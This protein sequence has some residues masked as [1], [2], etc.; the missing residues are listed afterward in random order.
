[1][2]KTIAFAVFFAALINAHFVMAQT[3]S[4]L[5]GQSMNGSTGL[6]SI[7]TG[8]LGWEKGGN[9]GLDLGYRAVI[10]NYDSATHIPAVTMSLFKWVE[11]SSAVDI[12]PD[13]Y[14]NNDLLFGLKVRLPTKK[15]TAIAL[16]GNVQFL[17][18]SNESNNYNAY[19]PYVAITYMGNFFSMSTETTVVF[20][21]TFYSGGPKNNSNIDFGMGFDMAL[22]PNVFKNVL[23]WVIDFANF[24]YSDNSWPNNNEYYHSSSM[25]RGIL[26]TGLR[27]NMSAIPALSR[28]KFLFDVAFNDLFDAGARSITLGAVFGFSP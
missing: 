23:H 1:M 4:S 28:Y 2:K 7:P 21:K 3:D 10:N 9:F 11:I 15:N 25:W 22:F 19:Q 26:N 16:G 13:L 14:R 20:G 5:N 24:N 17:N 18:I 6:Y 8:H 27:I 12:Q